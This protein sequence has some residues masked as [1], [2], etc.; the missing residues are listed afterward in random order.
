MPD[1]MVLVLSYVTIRVSICIIQGG[2]PNKRNLIQFRYKQVCFG[3]VLPITFYFVQSQ[4]YYFKDKL[5]KKQKKT[6]GWTKDYYISI[7]PQKT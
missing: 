1:N 5:E 3:S 2:W 4:N 7:S 6:N